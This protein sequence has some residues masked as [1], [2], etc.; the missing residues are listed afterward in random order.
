MNDVA[1]GATL[2]IACTLDGPSYTERVKAI[3]S[4]FAHA[5]KGARRDGAQ[6][7][8]T[9]DAAARAEVDD[10]V[11]KEKA[12]CAFLDFRITKSAGVIDLT[13]TVPADAADSADDLLA[14]F[15][16]DSAAASCGC[17]SAPRSRLPRILTGVSL[18][19]GG[20]TLACGAGCVLAAVL[21]A[22]G[23]GGALAANAESLEA[24][25]LPVLSA[26]VLFLTAAWVAHYRLGGT[27]RQLRGLQLATL[28]VILGAGFGWIEP[29][30]A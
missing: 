26:A 10:L 30:L 8:L 25:K 19:G 2:P 18:A 28:L 12:C 6:L 15:T 17:A 3:R 27:I 11:R 22:T 9:F 23:A 1:G 29:L 4:L 16:P 24:W 13:I 14:P 20:I 21:A 5:L 7:H